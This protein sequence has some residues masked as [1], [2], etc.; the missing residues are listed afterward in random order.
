M[1]SLAISSSQE[2]GEDLSGSLVGTS[3]GEVRCVVNQG[4]P[5]MQ[6]NREIERNASINDRPSEQE[7]QDEYRSILDSVPPNPE[8]FTHG[9]SYYQAFARLDNQ[10]AE[11][12]LNLIH[13]TA[14]MLRA[15]EA[16]AALPANTGDDFQYEDDSDEDLNE[17]IDNSLDRGL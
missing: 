14:S 15:K 13:T 9:M 10:V 4:E 17:A 11:R 7:I 16:L 3:K 8:T 2:K 12:S 5:L 6:E 1:E